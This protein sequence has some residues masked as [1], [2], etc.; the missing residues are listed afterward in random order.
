MNTSIPAT[1]AAVHQLSRVLGISLEENGKGLRNGE[2]SGDD[3]SKRVLPV[4]VSC[5]GQEFEIELSTGQSG[6]SSLG[7]HRSNMPQQHR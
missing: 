5:T 7:G 4:G 3:L 1:V 6:C 2:S